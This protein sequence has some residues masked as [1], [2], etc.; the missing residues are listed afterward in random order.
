[1]ADTN[2]TQPSA[3]EALRDRI[4]DVLADHMGEDPSEDMIDAVLDALAASQEA[5]KADSPE[6]LFEQY[7]LDGIARSPEP[8][9]E[10]GEYLTR[11]LDEDQWPT[12]ERLLLQLATATPT[13]PASQGDA[14]PAGDAPKGWP[15]RDD[16]S[17]W[18]VNDD[19]SSVNIDFSDFAGFPTLSILCK[20][21]GHVFV[22]GAG[23]SAPV[24]SPDALAILREVFTAAPAGDAVRE[25]VV[26]AIED[27]GRGADVYI[28]SKIVAKKI[29]EAIAA[30]PA[31]AVEREACQECEGYEAQGVFCAAC[32]TDWSEQGRVCKA[33][34]NTPRTD[35]DFCTPCE[36]AGMTEVAPPAEAREP[37]PA[38]L[39]AVAWLHTIQQGGGEHDQALSFAPDNFPLGDELGFRSLGAVPLFTQP[40][41]DA[42]PFGWYLAEDWLGWK[43]G[44]TFRARP[45]G[46]PTTT[47]PFIPLYVAPTEAAAVGLEM[48]AWSER[49]SGPHDNRTVRRLLLDWAK[50]LTTAQPQAT[51]PT[52]AADDMP[53]G[54][55]LELALCCDPWPADEANHAAV[56]AWL[57]ALARAEGFASWVDAYHKLDRAAV[58]PT[59]TGDAGLRR[60]ARGVEAWWLAEGMH[61]SPG[62]APACIFDLRQQLNRWTDETAALEVPRG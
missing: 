7:V 36:D 62:G 57:N 1:M 4:G 46:G 3:V 39:E 30:A 33:C 19:T 6:D 22:I 24:D 13:P 21:D 26:E 51:P 47:A 8:L 59:P 55:L 45:T 18:Y 42:E 29:I 49:L 16:D 38:V 20:A 54:R 50:R 41:S 23:R 9:R 25:L 15:T 2:T 43:K 28:A 53:F 17:Q 48:A 11:V 12:A 32:G 27:V 44:Y 56:E 14:A 58:I 10:L 35:S 31:P 60:A 37:A 40:P 34:K 5:P 52:P 61:Q